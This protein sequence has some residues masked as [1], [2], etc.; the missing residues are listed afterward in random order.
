[1]IGMSDRIVFTTSFVFWK[2]SLGL[3]NVG[4]SQGIGAVTVSTLYKRGA[5]VY[6]GDSDEI[7]GRELVESLRSN[8]PNT[9]GSVHFQE[10]NVRDYR[11]Q[12]QL[13]QTPYKE[14]GRVDVAVSC[15]AVTEPSGWF[16]TDD[17]NLETVI[18]KPQPLKDAID[19]NLTSVVLFCR[20]ALAYMDV[21]DDSKV[22]DNI[23]SLT[24]KSI[25][26]V[27]S[28]AGVVEQTGLFSYSSTKHGII[29]LMRSLRAWAL[30]KY[31]VRMNAI[32]PWATDTQMM[33]TVRSAWWEHG[34]PINT[35][36]E[37]SEFILQ[38]ATDKTWN[39][40]SVVVGSGRGFDTEGIGNTMSEWFGPE[41][42]RE[43]SRGQKV[44]GMV[45]KTPFN[46]VVSL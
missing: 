10:L 44:L 30:A 8:T 23:A 13:F 46:L 18:M 22:S 34:L 40:R 24:S 1:M 16:G 21:K 12:L 25:V 5:H 38:L 19:I 20:I 32:C 36:D 33:N 28:I 14:K 45:M 42:T 27:S 37:V 43:F 2:W 3:T 31:N 4:G 26:L 39:G 15:A 7:R 9:E 11:L 35:P 29:G 41:L 17:L 6:L